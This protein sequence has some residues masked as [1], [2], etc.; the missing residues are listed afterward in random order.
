MNK[1]QFI[2]RANQVFSL[3]LLIAISL[4][5][6]S[7]VFAVAPNPGHDFSTVSGGTVQGDLLYGSAADTLSAL[8]K[9]T[10]ATR[11][12]ANTGSSNNPAWAQIDLTNGVTGILPAGNGG[13]GNAF[14]AVTG[15]ASAIR[16]FTFPNADA[17]ILTSNAVVTVSQGGTG[18]AP[19]AGDQVLI[20]DSTSAATWKSINDCTGTGKAIT[21]ILSSNTIGC[22]TLTNALLDGALH[23]DT[24]AGSVVRGDVIIGNATPAWSR[25]AKGTA[26]QVLSMNSGATDVAW[27]TRMGYTLHVQALTSTPGDGLTVNFG[28]LPKAP[29]ATANI[30]KVYIPKTGTITRAQIY[31]Y[32]GTA[33][34]NEAW[35]LYV[36]LNDT[37][38]TLIET[39]SAAT[40]ER[41]FNN[42]AL[43]IAVTAGEYIEI[44]SIQPTW[45]TN[46]AT[47][48]YG[49]YLWI[50]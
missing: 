48:I 13:S 21:Y 12:I 18:A 11:Y 1:F 42:E 8:A 47:T 28:N 46:P 34:S 40:N 33:G 31:T 5:I 4:S 41:I 39:I 14:F 25:L 38:N 17:T 45:G 27:A 43:S 49:G 10:N 36:R 24:E 50:E 44:R 22:N 3:F 26:N 20:S 29:T 35:S 6:I 37:T 16:T 19:G 9:D 30:S 32:S 2:S 7:I 15:P 23:S